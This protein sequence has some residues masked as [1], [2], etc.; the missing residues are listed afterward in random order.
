MPRASVTRRLLRQL[1]FAQVKRTNEYYG[2]PPRKSKDRMIEQILRQTGTSLESFVAQ[3]GPF[4]LAEW[5]ETVVQ[6]GGAPRKSFAD[7]AAEI[8]CNLDPVFDEFDS[9]TSIT[10]LR[11]DRA[12][13]RT[14]AR[15]LGI[16][17]IDLKNQISE[18]NGHTLLSTFV[19]RIR[20]SQVRSTEVVQQVYAP[21][22]VASTR[23]TA[24]SIDKLSPPWMI[25]YIAGADHIAIA[26]GFYDIE[27]VEMLLL[28]HRSVQSV[29]LMFNGLGGSRLALQHDELGELERKLRKVGRS[30]DIRLKFA[31][32]MF[33]SKLFLVTERGSTRAL[34][35]SANA[36]TAAFSRNEEILVALADAGA[37]VQYFDTAWDGASKLDAIDVAAKSLIAFFRT[38]ILYFKPTAS[39]AT[40]LNPFRE[41]IK[42][43]L[44]EDRALLG[45][46][47]LPHAD[48]ETGIGAFN[49]KL[50]IGRS[51]L[52]DDQDSPDDEAI[53]PNAVQA[54]R[55]S[56][57]P[58]AIETCFGYWVPSKL[59][60]DLV[61]KLDEVGEQ[62][63]RRWEAFRD[64]LR[65]IS[66][67][68]LSQKYREYLDAVRIALTK[69]P[70][71][72]RY[73]AEL[74]RDPFKED[75]FNQFLAQVI[76][77]LDDP[78]RIERLSLPFT[79]GA[80][81][82]IWDDA[83]AYED[84]SRTFFDYLDLVARR[85]DYRPTVPSAILKVLNFSE[86]PG[87]DQ[88]LEQFE[89]YLENN[90]WNDDNWK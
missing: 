9:D 33:H 31:P 17:L 19:T 1:T 58:W 76:K 67:E 24:D 7:T 79:P 56:I 59:N 21:M 86:S 48:Q 26:A 30:V 49:L 68:E 70:N 63:K 82:E 85:E 11:T 57:K 39:L 4:S 66:D 40:T 72:Q 84:F 15:K 45:A 38:G 78:R 18:T 25:N 71:L 89:E 64:Q 29:R 36:T 35:G 73:L 75:I 46:V 69:I 61:R 65:A 55:A 77:H 47:E 8:E 43:M 60:D 54:T 22:R 2:Q 14:L 44:P 62:K 13:Q 51:E 90:G 3:Q 42:S 37:L 52:D 74:R 80:I 87:G 81:P 23:V 28:K 16:D 32:G 34:V 6:L 5:N 20:E 53:S 88:L 50:A 12:G 83:L 27:F 10:E 41:L